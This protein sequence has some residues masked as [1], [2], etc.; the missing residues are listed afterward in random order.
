MAADV[1]IFDPSTVIDHATYENPAALSEG[2]RH[3]FVNGV[4]A[5][6]DGTVTGSQGGRVLK[7]GT[8]LPS[9]PM[10][11]NV[12]RRV[13]V[14]GDAGRFGVRLDLS[15][16]PGARHA[17]GRFR[18][19]LPEDGATITATDFGVLQVTRDWAAFT[20]QAKFKPEGV[21]RPITVIVDRAD[22][23]SSDAGA[24]IIIEVEG[25][26]AYRGTVKPGMVRLG[27]PGS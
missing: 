3:V 23:L 16:Q 2:I 7:R 24:A 4:L 26:R 15:Q 22:P 19:D 25:A 14:K 6:R 12:P 13:E 10:T 18:V 9:R 11:A 20:A 27:V 1:T 17:R 21:V 5:L 8:G